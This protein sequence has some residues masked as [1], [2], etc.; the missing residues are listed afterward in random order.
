MVKK[1]YFIF[2]VII[3]LTVDAYS[4]LIDVRTREEW[5]TGFI[6][7]ATNIPLNDLVLEIDRHLI[8]NKE[9][10]SL[11]CR[12]GNRS[13]KAKLLLESLGYTKVKNIGGI[14][15]V[16]Q[17]LDLSIIK[18]NLLFGLVDDHL[19][20]VFSSYSKNFVENFYGNI[21][22][23]KRISNVELPENRLMIRYI[24]GES[25]LKFIVDKKH[26]Y[27]INN[28]PNK[29]NGI[30][31]LT[32][33]FPIESKDIILKKFKENQLEIFNYKENIINNISTVTIDLF[34]FEKNAI[35]LVFIEE[36][37][38]HYKYNYSKI[39]VNVSDLTEA[40]NYFNKILGLE[41]LEIQN[42]NIY[43]LGKTLIGVDKGI[44]LKNNYVG[45]P[46]E[47][48]GM[49]LIQFVVKD[50]PFSRGEILKRGG[51]IYIEPYKIGDLAIIM[52][53]QGPNGILFEFGA[54]VN[55]N[56]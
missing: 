22:N 23:L 6:E 33:Y 42:E 39:N 5:N 30:A 20:L 55:N 16:S 54:A 12:S 34:D 44:D 49:S 24:A 52:F 47:I 8:N 15:D 18:P 13:E 41:K 38:D 3:S 32:L 50:I 17:N 56:R 21:L 7:G 46:D 19:N 28:K 1:L 9:E 48:V 43:K 10:I 27:L 26:E 53:T 4:I 36:E 37:Y 35:E 29:F 2:I 25:E 45:M 51:E 40:D 14:N 11:Y 31:K